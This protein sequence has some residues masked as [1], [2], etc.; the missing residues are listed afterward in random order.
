MQRPLSLFLL[1]KTFLVATTVWAAPLVPKVPA[2]RSVPKPPECHFCELITETQDSLRYEQA[3]ACV[4]KNAEGQTLNRN[5]MGQDLAQIL[6]AYRMARK[7]VPEAEFPKSCIQTIMNNFPAADF[8]Y[9]KC[10][11]AASQ[12]T[13]GAGK[14]CMTSDYVNSVYNSFVDA[15]DCLE[16]DQMVFLPK[17]LNESGFHTN[18][19]NSR[20]FDSGIGQLTRHALADVN[21]NGHNRYARRIRD[22]MKPSCQR[23]AKV[24]NIFSKVVGTADQR[25]EIISAPANPFR[26]VLYTGMTALRIREITEGSLRQ[27]KIPELFVEAGLSSYN[28]E[29]LVAAL[30]ILGYNAGPGTAVRYLRDYLQGRIEKKKQR[31]GGPVTASDFDF[32]SQVE[33]DLESR[34]EI[35]IIYRA[36]NVAAKAEIEKQKLAM[37]SEAAIKILTAA[38]EGAYR[39]VMKRIETIGIHNISFPI[40]AMHAQNLGAYGY[41][42]LIAINKKKLDEQT[43]VGVCTPKQFLSL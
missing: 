34:K 23:L 31:L 9:A 19:F 39:D 28:H 14:H 26:N 1:M 16:V 27:A 11:T 32:Y 12:P 8:L 13:S 21:I 43:G 22:S 37:D 10:E 25:C 36:A 15:M 5:Y 4:S 3:K 41:G 17:L 18:A 40:Y 35:S 7:S 6:P 30:S 24:P 33:K 29:N 42:S 38:A 20:G 2:A